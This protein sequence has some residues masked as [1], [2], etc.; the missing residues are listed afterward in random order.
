[1]SRRVVSNAKSRG[2]FLFVNGKNLLHVN[3]R[4]FNVINAD[5][6]DIIYK[7]AYIVSYRLK[8]G[9]QWPWNEKVI[10]DSIVSI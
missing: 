7:K 3:G 5:S 1:M 8:P 4:K 9:F 6:F 10:I 2:L